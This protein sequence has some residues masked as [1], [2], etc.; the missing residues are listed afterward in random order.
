MNLTKLSKWMLL[1]SAA[2]P[3][4]LA[5]ATDDP[6]IPRPDR[7][8]TLKYL[9]DSFDR[10]LTAWNEAD[11]SYGQKT[12]LGSIIG[13]ANLAH[14]FDENGIQG[15][16][17]AYP[18]LGDGAYGYLNLG[19]SG[20]AIFPKFRTGGEAFFSVPWSM[21][22]SG[23]Y[24]YLKF[25]SSSVLLLT[26]SVSKYLGNYLFTV[27]PYYSPDSIGDSLSV[28]LLARRY[29]GDSDY[30]GLS[31]GA[32]ASSD[33]RQS[34]QEVFR[35]HSRKVG[36]EARISAGKDIA[37]LGSVNL[38]RQEVR[39]DTYRVDTTLSAGVERKF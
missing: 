1:I 27:R 31:I 18:H 30:V 2:A 12:S 7:W 34:T 20:D 9:H 8:A 37:L 39:P 15:E 24:R 25:Q 13:R 3:A 35:L 36:A 6:Q 33:Q 14:R 11:I 32:G 5:F 4:T 19:F 23:G 16:V 21:E 17:D 38:E 10:E 22:V 26:A 29:I 28:S